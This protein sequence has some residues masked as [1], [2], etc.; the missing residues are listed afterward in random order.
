MP[1]GCALLRA[2]DG[3]S[4]VP[5]ALGGTCQVSIALFGQRSVCAFRNSLTESVLRPDLGYLEIDVSKG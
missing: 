1:D 3:D 2:S 5:D 4:A